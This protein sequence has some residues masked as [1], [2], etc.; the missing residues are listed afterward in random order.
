MS[1]WCPDGGNPPQ[2]AACNGGE[3]EKGLCIL[4]NSWRQ[5]GTVHLQGCGSPER[6]QMQPCAAGRGWSAGGWIGT[7]TQPWAGRW[8]AARICGQ[9][10]EQEDI[11]TSQNVKLRSVLLRANSS[12]SL[13]PLQ[14]ILNEYLTKHNAV[15]PWLQSHH[16]ARGQWGLF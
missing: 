13:W 16:Q 15:A 8:R 12:A 4:Q 7:R 5:G 6:L 14:S 9:S 1:T 3:W 11:F 10:K 2:S